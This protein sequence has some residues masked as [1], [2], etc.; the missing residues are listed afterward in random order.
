VR[1]T[2]QELL[3]TEQQRILQ[4][5]MFANYTRGMNPEHFPLAREKK[6]GLMDAGLDVRALD[7]KSPMVSC[8]PSHL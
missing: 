8:A 7:L 4:P 6:I 3:G 5:A 1:L 2:G